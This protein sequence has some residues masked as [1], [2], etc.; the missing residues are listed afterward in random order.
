[1]WYILLLFLRGRFFDRRK[2]SSLEL[3]SSY[4]CDLGPD[5]TFIKSVTD[6]GGDCR[7]LRFALSREG[8][9]WQR[10]I[11]KQIVEVRIGT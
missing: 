3:R 1:M 2:I 11:S 6:P 9:H 7:S 5:L 4:L 8:G 10:E